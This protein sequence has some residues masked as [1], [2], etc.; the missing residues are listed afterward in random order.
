MG[1]SQQELTREQ[2]LADIEVSNTTS[3]TKRQV[4]SKAHAMMRDME[5]LSAG[6]SY[7]INCC[8]GAGCC[9]RAVIAMLSM[10]SCTPCMLD[11]A[12]ADIRSVS[13]LLV[14]IVLFAGNV[15]SCP[16]RTAAPHQ[17][18][19]HSSPLCAHPARL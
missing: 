17:P 12:K 9:H 16:Q 15:C 5:V 8:W 11:G 7:L 6:S 14:Y 4:V 1:G 2:Q 13:T 10:D 19:P 3:T 18:Q